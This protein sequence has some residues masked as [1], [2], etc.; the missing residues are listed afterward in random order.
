MR[1]QNGKIIKYFDSPNK[2]KRMKSTPSF[3]RIMKSEKL[4]AF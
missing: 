4:D 1:F 3:Y 2:K